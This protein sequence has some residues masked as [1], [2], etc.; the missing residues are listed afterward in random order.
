MGP[1]FDQFC[2]TISR[3]QVTRRSKNQKC[4]ELPQTDFEDGKWTELPYIHY[5]LLVIPHGLPCF[6]SKKEQECLT[7]IPT[8]ENSQFF[9]QFS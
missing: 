3:F 2:S 7:K 4:T 6:T 9:I 1:N 5:I 8:L